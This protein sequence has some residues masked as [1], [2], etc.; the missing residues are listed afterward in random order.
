MYTPNDR[1]QLAVALRANLR[2]SLPMNLQ[3]DGLCADSKEARK[4]P[5]TSTSFPG[6][7]HGHNPVHRMAGGHIELTLPSMSSWHALV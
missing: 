3:A 2:S 5:A 1:N 4:A 7:G 6:D